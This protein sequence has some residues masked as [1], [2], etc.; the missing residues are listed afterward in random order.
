MQKKWLVDYTVDVVLGFSDGSTARG[1]SGS[2][3]A[4]GETEEEAR[5]NAY[6]PPEAEITS[7]MELPDI[8]A[9]ML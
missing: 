1:L 2:V 5:A 4:K 8:L 3:I 7:V 9:K 6:L